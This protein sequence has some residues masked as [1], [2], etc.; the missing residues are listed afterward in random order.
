MWSQNNM[1]ITNPFTWP[2]YKNIFTGTNIFYR[3]T[4]NSATKKLEH[5][6]NKWNQY[7]NKDSKW[8]EMISGVC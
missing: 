4:K 5:N 2:F 7:Q 8:T 6:R 3:P 1:K